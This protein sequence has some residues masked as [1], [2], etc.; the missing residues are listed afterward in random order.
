MKYLLI[1]GAL[2]GGYWYVAKHYEF[3]DTLAYAKKN[4]GASWAP[5][6]DY[7]VGLMYYQRSDYKNAEEAFTQLLT[8]YP[9]SQYREL[10]LFY[11]EGA[12]END[13]NWDSARTLTQQYLDDFPN[14]KHIDIM[15]NRQENII[16]MHSATP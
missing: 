16:H 6:T 8:D 2:Y 15:K 13:G 10:G 3:H 14:G 7:Y 4:P 12:A 1:L 9:T 5:A 11:N